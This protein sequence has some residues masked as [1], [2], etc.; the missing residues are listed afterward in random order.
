ML[1]VDGRPA[2]LSALLFWA[3]TATAPAGEA[4]SQRTFVEALDVAS[5]ES[6]LQTLFDAYAKADYFT[7][8]YLLSAE[9]KTGFRNLASV[10]LSFEPLFPDFEGM[11]IPGSKLSDSEGVD[12]RNEVLNDT[13]LYFDDVMLAADRAGF[14]PFTFGP[15]V[16]ILRVET[17]DDAAVAEI[18]TDSDPANVSVRLVR[19]SSGDWRIDAISWEGSMTD[20][21]PW[22]VPPDSR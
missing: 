4:A 17:E 20:A 6:T 19:L 18:A 12:M 21:R 2:V 16:K 22:G 3:L 15:T 14:L 1:F 5:P 7:V 13:A 10:H 9:A 8:H 11:I